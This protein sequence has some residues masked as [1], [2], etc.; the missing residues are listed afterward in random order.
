[1]PACSRHAAAAD[2][3]RS[4]AVAGQRRDL[5]HRHRVAA[6]EVPD[7]RC[8]RGDE[9]PGR[10]D[11]GLCGLDPHRGAAEG[12]CRRAPAG[13]AVRLPAQAGR[14]RHRPE[15][16]DAA[17]AAGV[18]GNPLGDAAAGAAGGEGQGPEGG[19]SE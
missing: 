14:H 18:H 1:M 8:R 15:A 7:R 5:H 12:T 3:D 19:R 16:A 4:A 6:E 2:E 10:A 11:E 17:C 13:A 9:D